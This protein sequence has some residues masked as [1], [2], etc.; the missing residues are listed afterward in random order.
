M[1]N[2]QQSEVWVCGVAY[3]P[4]LV[5][6]KMNTTEMKKGYLFHTEWDDGDADKSLFG[7]CLELVRVD[8]C[9]AWR[10]TVLHG[11]QLLD[12]LWVVKLCEQSYQNQMAKHESEELDYGRRAVARMSYQNRKNEE[13]GME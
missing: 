12:I 10:P 2:Q 8:N 1:R 9:T 5:V 4:A 13:A 11:G 7:H 3:A 6:R